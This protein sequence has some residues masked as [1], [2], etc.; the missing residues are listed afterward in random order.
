MRQERARHKFW[1]NKGPRPPT[2]AAIEHKEYRIDF[3]A[4]IWNCRWSP[5]EISLAHQQK[6]TCT[7]Q[8]LSCWKK[9]CIANLI[10]LILW[11]GLNYHLNCELVNPNVCLGLIYT[12]FYS[13]SSRCKL[14]AYGKAELWRL[15]TCWTVLY[16]FLLAHCARPVGGRQYPLRGGITFFTFFFSFF[17][18]L[19]FSTVFLI[20]LVQLSQSA[21][22]GTRLQG[23][24]FDEITAIIWHQSTTLM[25]KVNVWHLV[26]WGSCY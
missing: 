4:C 15:F 26:V 25:I 8:K 5:L 13:R 1:R 12:S 16:L 2:A 18:S 21:V 11:R 14:K 20:S 24:Y 3:W 19:C 7:I 17:L 22:R 9:V 10:Q 6:V 23:C